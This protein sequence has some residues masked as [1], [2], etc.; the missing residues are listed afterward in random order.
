M[1]PRQPE[2]PRRTHAALEHIRWTI[3]YT[4][5][6]GEVPTV[7]SISE[8]LEPLPLEETLQYICGLAILLNLQRNFVPSAFQQRIVELIAPPPNGVSEK[9]ISL[10]HDERAILLH[11]EQL[12][13]LACLLD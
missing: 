6:F 1:K 5:V 11:P 12:A 2:S 13:G 9:V 7:Q 8:A 4:H 3:D 10:L